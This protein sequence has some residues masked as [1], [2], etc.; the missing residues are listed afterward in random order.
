MESHEFTTT[1][2]RLLA[3]RGDKTGLMSRGGQSFFPMYA[4]DGG[5][6]TGLHSG[7]L[8]VYYYRGNGMVE[9]SSKTYPEVKEMMRYNA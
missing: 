8:A 3:G 2:F 5:L 1:A 6:M 4:P 9:A 7:V